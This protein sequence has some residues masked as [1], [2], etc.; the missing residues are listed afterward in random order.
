MFNNK[1]KMVFQPQTKEELKTAVNLYCEN[2]KQA[3]EKYG[4]INTWDVSKITDMSYLFKNKSEF[5]EDISNWN[6]SN[7]KYMNEMFNY[8]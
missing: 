8:W 3:I 1:V 7:V 6:V 2:K 5:D 4:I